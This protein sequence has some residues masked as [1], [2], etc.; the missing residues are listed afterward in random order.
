MRVLIILFAIILLLV[1]MPLLHGFLVF[2]SL[3]N[4]AAIPTVKSFFYLFT[5]PV[6]A[7][8]IMVFVV[9]TYRRSFIPSQPLINGTL[10]LGLLGLVAPGAGLALSPVIGKIGLSGFAGIAVLGMLV[11]VMGA[12]FFNLIVSWTNKNQDTD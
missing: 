11:G 7:V 2:A 9:E 6:W 10:M 8:V 12:V 5:T 1:G 4:L 3:N